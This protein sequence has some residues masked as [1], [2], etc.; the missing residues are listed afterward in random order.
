MKE[1]VQIE[2]KEK[3][4]FGAK[5]VIKETQDIAAMIA[6]G[7]LIAAGLFRFTAHGK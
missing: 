5:K 3:K 6:L 7:V 1:N 2:P 4:P